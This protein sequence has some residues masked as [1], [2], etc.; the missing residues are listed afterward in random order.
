MVAEAVAIDR[1]DTDAL[2]QLQQRECS[3]GFGGARDLESC[4][5]D[6][7]TEARAT[8]PAR[9]VAASAC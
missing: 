8:L 4:R 6:V 1:G 3:S 7:E 2:N 9:S 5:L